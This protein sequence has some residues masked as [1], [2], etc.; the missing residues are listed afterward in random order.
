MINKNGYIDSVYRFLLIVSEIRMQHYGTS[1]VPAANANTNLNILRHYTNLFT[2]KRR[3]SQQQI[4]VTTDTYALF[5]S[6]SY[7]S[8]VYPYCEPISIPV[9][10]CSFFVHV[11]SMVS[12]LILI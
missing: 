4:H 11:N 2:T 10:T 12:E 6:F 7:I 5:I 8:V 3:L 9:K 1:G